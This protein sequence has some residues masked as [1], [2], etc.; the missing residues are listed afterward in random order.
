[1]QR[2]PIRPG[3]PDV[4]VVDQVDYLVCAGGLDVVCRPCQAGRIFLHLICLRIW[5]AVPRSLVVPPVSAV[6]GC[7]GCLAALAA[8]LLPYLSYLAASLPAVCP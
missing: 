8:A 4:H 3:W 2:A 7:P 6:S 1:M 5:A